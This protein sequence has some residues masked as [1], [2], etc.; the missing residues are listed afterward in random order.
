MM[1]HHVDVGDQRQQSSWL[2]PSQA[3]ASFAMLIWIDVVVAALSY[4]ACF[5]WKVSR[6]SELT[7]MRIRP[8]CNE[9]FQ[10]QPSIHPSL[11]VCLF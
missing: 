6:A 4:S 8:K 1:V 7:K 3:N 10:Q 5:P 9:S 11:F 2:G